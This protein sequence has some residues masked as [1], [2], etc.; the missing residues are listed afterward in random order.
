MNILLVL[1]PSQVQCKHFSWLRQKCIYASVK[2]IN[3]LAPNVI[4]FESIETFGGFFQ[5]GLLFTVNAIT[6]GSYWVK[7]IGNIWPHACT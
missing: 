3:E 5:R 2:E 4:F 7:Q 1:R 6:F